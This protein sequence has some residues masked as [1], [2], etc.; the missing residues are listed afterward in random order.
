M[1]FIKGGKM[2]VWL[3]FSFMCLKKNEFDE[4]REIN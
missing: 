3:K 1:V 2:V 4:M